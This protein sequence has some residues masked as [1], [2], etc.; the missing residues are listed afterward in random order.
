MT[1]TKYGASPW[2]A[3]VAKTQRPDYPRYRGERSVQVAIVGGG[4][5]GCLT[6]YA[7]A[8]AGV[9]VVVLEADRIAHQGSGRGPGILK[10][11]PTQSYR[12]LEQRHGRRAAR[13]M[14]DAS[15]RAVLDLAATTRRLG[16]R[17]KVEPGDAL[18]VLTALSAD[19]KALRR[20]AGAATRREPRSGVDERP[21][22]G[23]QHEGRGRPRRG[24]AA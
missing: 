1:R 15:R 23:T 11:E 22:C 4:L 3:E 16:L 24:A 9:R 10:G 19:E 14:F 18:R 12:D 5:T 6:A 7:F 20:E 17:V 8:A 2:I 13:A 21:G